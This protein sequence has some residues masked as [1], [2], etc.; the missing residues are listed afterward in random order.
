MQGNLPVSLII[1]ALSS[2]LQS[3]TNCAEKLS[4]DVSTALQKGRIS[5]APSQAVTGNGTAG[6]DLPNGCQN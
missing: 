4:L 2:R 5:P 1:G 6:V 3:P